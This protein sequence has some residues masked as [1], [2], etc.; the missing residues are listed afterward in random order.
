MARQLGTWQAQHLNS[1]KNYKTCCTSCRI[2]FSSHWKLTISCLQMNS[3]RFEVAN[4][5]ILHATLFLGA[6]TILRPTFNYGR[7]WEHL[8]DVKPHRRP[9]R[10]T[11][12]NRSLFPPGGNSAKKEGKGGNTSLKHQSPSCCASSW[13]EVCSLGLRLNAADFDE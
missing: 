12:L 13:V 6:A 1:Q 5:Q 10:P 4:N 2:T 7:Q 11:P 9:R 3:F 8:T